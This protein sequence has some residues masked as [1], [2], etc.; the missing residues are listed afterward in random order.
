MTMVYRDMKSLSSFAELT[1]RDLL[2]EVRRLARVERQATADLI[3]SLSEVDAR[4]LY[5][6]EGCSSLFTYCTHVLH[7]SEHAAYG[8][9]EAACAAR[10]FP[11]ILDM[12]RDGALTLTS[13]TLLSAH[14]TPENHLPVLEAARHKTKR[15]VELIVAALRP[16]P[17]VASVVRKVSARPLPTS[18]RGLPVES[19]LA[20]PMRPPAP[21]PE[22]SSKP[23]VIAPLTPEKYKLQ[24]T[25]SRE[26]HDLLR[27]AQDLLR[28]TVP[29]GDPAAIVERALALLVEDLERKKFAAVQHPR[30]AGRQRRGSRHVPASVKRKVWRRDEGRCAFVGAAGRCAERGFL[31]LHHLV[32]FAEGGATDV[33]NL[34]LRCRAHNSY[35]AEQWFG[36]QVVREMSEMY[37][38]TRSR[39]S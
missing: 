20:Q 11:A 37:E 14:L 17:D 38:A 35:E 33:A 18:T 12:L 32:P 16:R 28:H 3:A 4:R 24:V 26:A 1:D 9:I 29:N 10:R 22:T 6:G 34:Q 21:V 25:I 8:R 2:D 30:S 36:P 27:R 39:P 5:L 7:L 13:V 31:E 23:G 19:A 15:E